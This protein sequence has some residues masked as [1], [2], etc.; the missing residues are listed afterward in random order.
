VLVVN[1]RIQLQG[2]EAEEKKRQDQDDWDAMNDFFG[3]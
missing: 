1:A 3:E 2:R